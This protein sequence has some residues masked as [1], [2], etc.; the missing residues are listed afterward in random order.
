MAQHYENKSINDA[1]E[2]LTTN[3][4]DGLAEAVTV[5]LNSAMVAER[6]EYLGAASYERCAQRVSYASGFKDK[7]LNTRLGS[8]SL[9]VPQNGGS[10]TS[11]LTYFCFML[12]TTVSNTK[13]EL[14]IWLWLEAQVPS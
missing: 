6:S 11:L 5:L 4:F 3:G 14:I 9:K 7:A 12:S 13:Q 2:L 8:L 1:W 10:G